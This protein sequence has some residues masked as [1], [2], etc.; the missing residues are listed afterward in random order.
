MFLRSMYEPYVHALSRFLLMPRCGPEAAD[1]ERWR[2]LAVY[3]VDTTLR[4]TDTAENAAAF[5]V[6][7]RW[8]STGGSCGS[9]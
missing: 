7:T 3:R 6:A 4:V 5:G 2:G 9:P 1:A 8:E